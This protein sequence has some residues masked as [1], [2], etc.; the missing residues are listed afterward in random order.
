MKKGLLHLL[1]VFLLGYSVSVCAQVKN[2]TLKGF[3]AVPGGESFSYKLVFTDSADIV[4]GY[5]LTYLHEGKETKALIT[6]TVDK[7]A[8]T[9]HFRETEIVYNHGFESQGTMCLINAKLNYVH[10][11]DANVLTGRLN[12]A[13]LSNTDCGSGSVTF[14]NEDGINELFANAVAEAPA[15]AA[16][17]QPPHGKVTKIIIEEP[18]E[19]RPVAAPVKTG[20]DEV[21]SG[22]DKYYNWTSDTVKMYVWD[23]GNIDG[24]KITVRFNGRVVLDKYTLTA[25]KKAVFLLASNDKTDEVTITADNEGN[26]PPNT[27][28]VQLWDGD[29]KYDLLVYNPIGQ[30]GIIRI[31]KTK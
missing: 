3:I 24:D 23:G 16:K 4:N 17:P 7:A 25:S 28:N 12:S 20:P 29:K 22:K 8:R 14:I 26:E 5:S 11:T 13:D 6:G 10:K 31:K 18:R 27:A 21:T 1:L 19:E 15:P 30:T 2:I 9:F